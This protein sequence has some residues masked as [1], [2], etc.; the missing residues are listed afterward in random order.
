[1][2]K[3]VL[4]LLVLCF[5]VAAPAQNLSDR[6]KKA[7]SQLLDDP[8]MRYGILGW[9]VIDA[10]SGDTLVSWNANTGLPPASCL[11]VIT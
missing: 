1:M 5:S 4:L 6:L 3:C 9:L 11:K 7:T 8:Q 10:D 2:K